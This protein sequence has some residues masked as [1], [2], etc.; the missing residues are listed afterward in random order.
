MSDSIAQVRQVVRGL[1]E[2]TDSFAELP[3]AERKSVSISLVKILD[4]LADPYAGIDV[5]PPVARAQAAAPEMTANEDLPKRMSERG[6]TAGQYF[7]GGA[8]KQAGSTFKDLVK[9]AA[10]PKFVSG[11]IEGVF[12]S[13]VKSSIK[14]MQA[15]QQMLEGITKSVD[16]FAKGTISDATAREYLQNAYPRALEMKV[17]EDGS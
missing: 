5:R 1:L 4:Y 3:A 7:E 17:D 13:I 10:F 6:P 14:Q 2:N 12:S 16:A 11:L 9:A 8:A 15:F